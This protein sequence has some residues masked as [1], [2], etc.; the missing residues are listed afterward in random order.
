MIRMSDPEPDSDETIDQ[1]RRTALQALATSGVATYGLLG[2]SGTA[3]AQQ[4]RGQGN[5]D[6]Q[7]RGRGRGKWARCEVGRGHGR[8]GSGYKRDHPHSDDDAHPGR[9]RGRGRGRGPRDDDEDE[10]DED[11]PGQGRGPEEGRGDGEDDD[12]GDD[13]DDEGDSTDGEDDTATGVV[14]VV[15]QDGEPVEG[16]PVTVW[17]PGTVE[18]EA[19]ETYLTDEDGE[20]EIELLAGEPED[21]PMFTIEVRDQEEVLAIMS[22]EHAGVQE[23]EFVVDTSESEQLVVITARDAETAQAIEGATVSIMSEGVDPDDV[24]QFEF[25]TDENGRV[26]EDIEIGSFISTVSAEGYEDDTKDSVSLEHYHHAEL[27][28]VEESDEDE[29]SDDEG[30][31]EDGDDVASLI[32]QRIHA[33]VNGYRDDQGLESLSFSGDLAEV[34]REHSEAMFEAERLSHD[35]DGDG[36]GDRISDAGLECDGWAE[37]IAMEYTTDL[38]ADEDAE[39]VADSVVGGWVGEPNHEQNLTGD[40]SGQGIGVHVED[41]YVY[42]TQ[43]LC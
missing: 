30:G 5:A 36:P 33:Q 7:G 18:E 8:R 25:T 10:G 37:N 40:F 17:P 31:S 1:K 32:E 9:G 24:Q 14:R 26:E 34:A 21:A 11:R 15:N 13:E 19:T 3:A 12:E 20:Y 29:E 16:E 23:V 43:L 6:S 28:P 27:E 4:G 39:S 42:V 38:D 2:F 35:L 22:D 41:D